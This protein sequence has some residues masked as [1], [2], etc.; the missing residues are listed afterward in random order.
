MQKG[1]PDE[2]ATPVR[3]PVTASAAARLRAGEHIVLSGPIWRLGGAGWERIRAGSRA[4]QPLPFDVAGA[5]LWLDPAAERLPAAPNGG[6]AAD[7]AVIHL[8][9]SGLAAIISERPCTPSIRYAL[10]KYG[11]LAIRSQRRTLRSSGAIVAFSDLG[12]EALRAIRVRRLPAVVTVDAHGGEYR[13]D[14]SP[15]RAAG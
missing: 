12:L 4:L 11:A 13:V 10:R 14:R 1:V 2:G 6:D 5:V 9:A 3:V 7:A 15:N 8:I